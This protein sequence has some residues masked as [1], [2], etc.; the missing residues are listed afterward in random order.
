MLVVPQLDETEESS[1]WKLYF[2]LNQAARYDMVS[3]ACA[4]RSRSSFLTFSDNRA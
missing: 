3:S 4:R 2:G 1:I